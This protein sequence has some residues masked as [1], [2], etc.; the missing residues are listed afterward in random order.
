[1]KPASSPLTFWVLLLLALIFYCLPWVQTPATSLTMGAYDLAEWASL[2][3]T[4]RASSPPLLL[5]FTLRLPLALL[6]L[7]AAFAWEW[8]G[9]RRARVLVVCL[10]SLALLPPLEFFTQYRDDPNY[11][12]QFALAVIT[13]LGGGIGLTARFIRWRAL[14]FIVLALLGMVSSLWGLWQGFTLLRDFHLSLSI[15]FGGLGLAL[16]F[17]TMVV[18]CQPSPLF[19]RKTNRVARA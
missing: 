18:L 14:I 4:V 17:L 16:C 19:R 2:N 6:A 10:I 1:M 15:G 13:L 3:P 12:Q 8:D 5:S 11:R 9:R 7:I